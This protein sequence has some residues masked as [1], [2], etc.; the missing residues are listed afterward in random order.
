MAKTEKEKRIEI[1]TSLNAVKFEE[2]LDVTMLEE[3]GVEVLLD[4][5][6]SLLVDHYT[7]IHEKEDKEIREKGIDN[8]HSPIDEIEEKKQIEKM[9]LY[10]LNAL[11]DAKKE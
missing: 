10:Y 7:A 2:L 1:S 11:E 8:F 6:V 5:A 9:K 4:E 3:K